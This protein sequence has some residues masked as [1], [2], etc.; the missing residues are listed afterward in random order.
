MRWPPGC[1]VNWT[2]PAVRSIST[3]VSLPKSGSI[4]VSVTGVCAVT[5]ELELNVPD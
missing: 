4:S 2:W 5:G 1:T 3:G